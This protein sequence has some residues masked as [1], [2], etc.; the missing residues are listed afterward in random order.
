MNMFQ[1]RLRASIYAAFRDSSTPP[2]IEALAT[3]LEA[4]REEVAAGLRALADEHCLV[5]VPGTESSEKESRDVLK[6]FNVPPL[7]DEVAVPAESRA[8]RVGVW[9]AMINHV[10]PWDPV[11]GV[12]F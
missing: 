10:G 2:S 8:S 5:L 11:K 6:N 3:A 4:S 1:R 7:F 9:P 12:A